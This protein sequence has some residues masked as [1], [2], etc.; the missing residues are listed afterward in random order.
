MKSQTEIFGLVI[1]VLLVSLLMIMVLVF[2]VK[3]KGTDIQK[4]YN[5]KQL[6]INTMK[7]MLT[8]NMP[9]C[10]NVD[11]ND[12]I[13]DCFRNQEL[14]C[15]GFS[16]SCAFVDNATEE[17]MQDTVILWGKKYRFY[18]YKKGDVGPGEDAFEIASG[19]SEGVSHSNTDD[20]CLSATEIEPGDFFLP[21]A[22]TT[23]YLR[24]DICTYE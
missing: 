7:A 17:I 24:L 8:T 2:V 11:L 21:A 6:A 4:T 3:D 13:I 18:A 9:A 22:G 10:R 12:V 5:D 23:I 14:Y 20:H 15:V 19:T 1:V 16:D